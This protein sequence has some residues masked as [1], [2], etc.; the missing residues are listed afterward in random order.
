MS[1]IKID[2]FIKY[3]LIVVIIVACG[4]LG[5][6]WQQIEHNELQFHQVVDIYHNNIDHMQQHAINNMQVAIMVIQQNQAIRNAYLMKDRELLYA[7]SKTIFHEL[8]YKFNIVHFYFHLPN[9]VN[10]LRIHK[11]EFYGDLIQRETLKE[12]LQQGQNTSGLELGPLGLLALRVV[13]PWYEGKQLIGFIELGKELSQLTS[14]P[15]VKVQADSYIFVVKQYLDKEVWQAN[16][17][18]SV[19]LLKWETFTNHILINPIDKPLPTFLYHF[20]KELKADKPF[21]WFNVSQG[22][23]FFNVGQLQIKNLLGKTIALM[24]IVQD[25]TKQVKKS[26]QIIVLGL[27]IGTLGSIGLSMLFGRVLKPLIYRLQVSEQREML[28]GRILENS[29]NPIILFN[30]DSFDITQINQGAV[31]IFGYSQEEMDGKS[32]VELILASEFT[33]FKD[34]FTTLKTSISDHIH[35]ELTLCKKDQTELPAELHLQ[36]YLDEHPPLVVVMVQNLTER[37]QH[38]IIKHEFELDLMAYYAKIQDRERH[39]EMIQE[40]S[41]D[42]IITIDANGHV[43]AVNPAAEVMFGYS[44]QELMGQ[45]IANYIIPTAF[46]QAHKEALQRHSQ[47]VGHSFNIKRRVELPGLRVDGRILELEVGLIVLN[48]A[49][50]KHY[51][52][53]LHDVTERNQLMKSLENALQKTESVSQMKSEFLANMSHEM[54]TPMNSILGLTDLMLNTTISPQEQKNNLAVIFT[55]SNALLDLINGILDLSKIDAGMVALD[56]MAF[57]LAGQIESACDPLAIKAHQKGVEFNC[58]IANNLPQTVVGDPSRLK[59][60]LIN[61]VNNAIKFTE[62]GE[63]TVR[64]E[65]ARADV[66]KKDPT[67]SVE[68]VALHFSVADTGIGISSE[69]QA[70]VFDR[71]TQVDG[72]STRQFGG[73]G[74]GLTICKHLVE[75]MGGELKLESTVGQGT[76]FDFVIHCGVAQRDGGERGHQKRKSV[77]Q[78]AFALD[79][80]QGIHIL[81]ADRHTTGRMIVREILSTTEAKVE[82]VE[83]YDGLLSQL[84][85]ADSV[86][87]PFD[88]LILDYDMLQSKQVDLFD[89]K[90][91]CNTRGNAVVLLPANVNMDLIAWLEGIPTAKAV[92]K[93]VW[94]FRLLIAIRQILGREE[95]VEQTLYPHSLAI[96]PLPALHI[97]LAESDLQ[98]QKVA[99]QILEEVGHRVT[100]VE[101]AQQIFSQLIDHLCDLLVM[102][103]SMPTVDGFEVTGQIR[104]SESSPLTKTRV[105]ILAVTKQISREEE[106]LCLAAGM[107]GYMQKP[108]RS[109]DLLSGIAS[110]I[111]SRQLS[112]SRAMQ[113]HSA[114]VLKAVDL[115]DEVFAQRSGAFIQHFPAHLATLQN[116]ITKQNVI[117]AEPSVKWLSQQSREIGAWK[118]STQSLRLRGSMEQKKWNDS[119]DHWEKLK[120]HCQEVMQAIL[121][122]GSPV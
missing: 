70:V 78:S 32:F 109:R 65:L 88:L 60:I 107:D 95:M 90:D 91:Y 76:L 55:A 13:V 49:G 18:S 19:P 40:Y 80:L 30:A 102:D 25:N 92:S 103:L 99:I 39:L 36:L 74:L 105:A 68:Q 85:L 117:Q 101:D 38:E 15:H 6:Y 67:Q 33:K 75:L 84:A 66:F 23:T 53:F 118:V 22:N 43:E 56:Q 93:P 2:T 81:L 52:A 21:Y 79:D 100:V 97:L 31:Q 54:R 5:V 63:V 7:Q 87:R 62:S 26:Q 10:F 82:E 112:N 44:K 4:A 108:Y 89:L 121:E 8:K 77:A 34:H 106:K 24:V 94:K 57:D 42:A 35:F 71:F 83:S 29:R 27:L 110:A 41:M 45:D 46:R 59:Q 115:D 1:I 58:Y 51:T 116:A 64:V 47:E 114:S 122:K 111:K 73:V 113:K 120:A 14:V 96:K 119:Q 11:P 3:I 37:K 48:L 72:S 86:K 17:N 104:T 9:R 61:L 28:L 12:A 69:M 20:E 16:V 50:T 98:N